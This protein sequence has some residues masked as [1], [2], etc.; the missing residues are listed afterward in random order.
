MIIDCTE[1]K[2]YFNVGKKR[3]TLQHNLKPSDKSSAKAMLLLVCIFYLS[4]NVDAI[5][6]KTRM[7][8]S[9]VEA[10]FDSVP[11]NGTIKKDIT[12]ISIK[13]QS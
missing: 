10:V 2:N 4:W 8:K 6:I 7:R 5:D 3:K 12:F 1:I 11:S 9:A 13:L